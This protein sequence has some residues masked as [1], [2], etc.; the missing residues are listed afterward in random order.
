MLL[1]FGRFFVNKATKAIAYSREEGPRIRRMTAYPIAE[2]K[3]EEQRG[4]EKQETTHVAPSAALTPALMS[5]SV[6]L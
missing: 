3:S 2:R 6:T 5:A 4:D 1:R